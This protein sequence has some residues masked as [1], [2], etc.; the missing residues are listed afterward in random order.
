MNLTLNIAL[1]TPNIYFNFL[2]ILFA[3]LLAI[4]GCYLITITLFIFIM[5]TVEFGIINRLLCSILLKV[6]L[7]I[8]MTIID[9]DYFYRCYC[10]L[11]ELLIVIMTDNVIFIIIYL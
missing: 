6:S 10:L 2:I 9:F 8:F 11:L 7:L 3:N 5:I 4:I 1:I